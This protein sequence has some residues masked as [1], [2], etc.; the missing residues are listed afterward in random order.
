MKWIRGEVSLR[1]KGCDSKLSLSSHKVPPRARL[2]PKVECIAS[3]CFK[4]LAQQLAKV[5]GEARCQESSAHESKCYYRIIIFTTIVLGAS[6]LPFVGEEVRQSR[7]EEQLL[8]YG[9]C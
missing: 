7:V 4:I 2:E 3:F 5:E 9:C 6:S 1:S 8:T